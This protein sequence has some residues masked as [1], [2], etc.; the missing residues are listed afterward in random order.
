MS[1]LP[2]NIAF[3]PLAGFF[4]LIFTCAWCYRIRAGS[5]NNEN[6]NPQVVFPAISELG[7]FEGPGRKIYQ[8][9]F[10]LVGLAI[11]RTVQQ[12]RSEVAPALQRHG[13]ALCDGLPDQ[14]AHLAHAFNA[15]AEQLGAAEQQGYIAAFGVALQGI[16]TLDLAGLA[17]C[18]VHWGGAVAAIH[19]AMSHSLLSIELY[20]ATL[21][22]ERHAAE[23]ARPH[24]PLLQALRSEG[25]LSWVGRGAEC[26]R[27]LV[28]NSSA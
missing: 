23:V 9:G 18:F 17:Q 19:G 8:V 16:F 22:L 4:G 11:A 2:Q 1:Q 20:S 13:R 24:Q 28:E 15:A 26:R 21:A 6:I 5:K 10:C 12:W 14:H 27:W 7:A 3:A 25:G